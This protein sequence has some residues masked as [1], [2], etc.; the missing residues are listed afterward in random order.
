[1]M[2]ENVVTT[3]GETTIEEVVEMLYTKHIGSVLILDKEN[4]CVGIFTERDAIRVIATG[5]PTS[6]PLKNAMTT[7]P[8]TIR[9][10]ASFAEA[11]RLMN[12]HHIRHL[13]VVDN[14]DQ[15]IGLL[16][17]RIIL[18]ELFNLHTATG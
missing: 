12:T 14:Q 16:S 3:T 8:L 18:D 4:K 7:N 5:I 17:L 11:R 6:T 10:E 15:L 13:P 1:M 9:E 2:I